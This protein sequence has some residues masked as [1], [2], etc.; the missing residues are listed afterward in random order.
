MKSIDF[1]KLHLTLLG[2]L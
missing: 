1:N 2:Q